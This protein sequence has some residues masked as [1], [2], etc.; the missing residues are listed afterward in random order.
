[1]TAWTIL[2]VGK[3]RP[4]PE[5]ALF[6]HYQMR[7]R[8]RLHLVEVEEKRPLPVETRKLREAELLLD[9]LPRN[10]RLVVLDERGQD[11]DT[12][13]LARCLKRWS[14]EA[15]PVVAFAIGGADGHGEAVLQRAD[16]TISMGRMTW[17][18]MLVRALVAEQLYRVACIHSGHPYHR[19]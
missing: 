1:M 9:R 2:A 17:P 3:A 18:H 4:G 14:E 10:A 7:L 5:Q 8:G 11:I 19:E 13:S 6:D 12:L 15:L 16:M